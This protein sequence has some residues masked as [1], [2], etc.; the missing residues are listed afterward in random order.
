VA[1]YVL[2][3]ADGWFLTAGHVFDLWRGFELHL[4]EVR[5]YRAA[6]DAITADPSLRACSRIRA[7]RPT[8]T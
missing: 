2:L 8:S 7:L 4:P 3:N 5:N 1:T 6:E